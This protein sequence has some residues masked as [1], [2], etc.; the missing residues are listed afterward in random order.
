MGI[1]NPRETLVVQ[2]DYHWAPDVLTHWRLVGK[3]PSLAEGQAAVKTFY[4]QLMSAVADIEK[5]KKGD[6]EGLSA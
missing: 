2:D 6:A 1:E 3:Y 4:E 5:Q